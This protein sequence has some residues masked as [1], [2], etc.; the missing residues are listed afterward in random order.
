MRITEGVQCQV[1]YSECP[2]LRYRHRFVSCSLA[3]INNQQG[4]ARCSLA[5]SEALSG[6]SLLGQSDGGLISLGNTG[7]LLSGVEFNVAVG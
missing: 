2:M 1:D 3:Q 4:S 7:L 6:G 5:D